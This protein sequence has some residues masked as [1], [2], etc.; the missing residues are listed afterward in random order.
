MALEIEAEKRLLLKADA[1]IEAGW[2]RLRNQQDLL[3]SLLAAEKN[4]RE[5]EQLLHLMQQALVEWQRRCALIEQPIAYLEHEALLKTRRWA[6]GCR[7][8]PKPWQCGAESR[9]LPR[10]RVSL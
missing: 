5:A 6:V 8:P 10:N 1:D 4:T 7:G 2:C 9:R 3:S